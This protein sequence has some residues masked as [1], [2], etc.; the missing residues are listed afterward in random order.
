MRVWKRKR[1]EILTFLWWGDCDGLS[2]ELLIKV[3]GV[4]LRRHLRLERRNELGQ[5]C[6][7]ITSDCK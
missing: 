4:C 3:S 1:H 7:E 2:C 5:R 6:E